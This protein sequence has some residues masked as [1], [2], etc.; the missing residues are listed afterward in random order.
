MLHQNLISGM[1]LLTLLVFNH[2]AYADQLYRRSDARVVAIGFGKLDENKQTVLFA[3]CAGKKSELYKLKEFR[4]QQGKDCDPVNWWD[5][6]INSLDF[7]G[8]TKVAKADECAKDRSCSQ[9][10]ITS[11]EK[12]AKIFA[13]AKRGDKI[14]V[15]QSKESPVPNGKGSNV[16][17]RLL[18][19]GGNERQKITF[20]ESE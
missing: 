16:R 2:D 15:E 14:T 5:R 10:V 11:P 13:E 1:G 18:E 3:D 6:A 19:K 9:W 12:V 4:F 17:V 8:T 20:S 7:E